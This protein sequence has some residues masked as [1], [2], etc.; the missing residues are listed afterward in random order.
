MAEPTGARTFILVHN[1]ALPGDASTGL[2]PYR[3]VGMST[4]ESRTDEH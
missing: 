1:L 2:C 3:W 4:A